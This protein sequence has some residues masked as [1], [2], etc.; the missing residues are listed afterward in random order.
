MDEH[1]I[2]E[3]IAALILR[4]T[5]EERTEMASWFRD[6]LAEGEPPDAGTMALFLGNWASDY[7]A[8]EAED[9]AA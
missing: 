3:Q 7:L 4:Q 1:S 6:A 9:E 2:N 8:P 5:W